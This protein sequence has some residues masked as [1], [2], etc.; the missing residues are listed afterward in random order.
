MI[1]YN[2]LLLGIINVSLIKVKN[3]GGRDS[4]VG[5]LSTS[6]SGDPGS[7]PSCDLIQINQCK[8][9]RGRDYQL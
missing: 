1:S 6:Q 7:N 5:K 3:L 4:L 9:E 2:P 8:N